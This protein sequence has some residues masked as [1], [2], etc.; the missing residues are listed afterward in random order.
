MIREAIRI[1]SRDPISLLTYVVLGKDKS[2]DYQLYEL[3]RW[4]KYD[5][6][7]INKY[8]HMLA[9]ND[10]FYND[11]KEKLGGVNY[12]QIAF[13]E[14]IYV[15]V[16]MVKPEIVVE[17]GVS[18][19]V[20][21]AYIL[22]ALHDNNKGKLYSID[23]PNYTLVEAKNVEVT[24]MA[25]P[26]YL[27]YRWTLLMGKSSEQ[28]PALLRNLDDV[29]MFVHDS[30]HSYGN[31]KQEYE[32]VWYKIKRKGLLVSHDINDNKAFRE[33]AGAV[34]QPNREIYFTGLGVIK[35]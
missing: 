3:V 24:G 33:F 2:L 8:M 7:D 15:L 19:G 21:S 12:G 30:E 27:R 23:Y 34:N 5:T 13:P 9:V 29:D 26:C 17:T 20:S 4:L 28:L 1:G 14:L 22:Q 32:T 18:A 11:V 10:K 16:S 31:M 6:K 25:V 35:K